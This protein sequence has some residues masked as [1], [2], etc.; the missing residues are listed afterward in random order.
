[1]KEYSWEVT[2]Y[3][4]VD[5]DDI[6]EELESL[7]EDEVYQGCD[8]DELVE[9]AVSRSL[10]GLDDAEYYSLTSEVTESIIQDFKEWKGL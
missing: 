7:K 6:N 10:S 2:L 1:M 9:E 3:A 4:Q 8:I 5:F